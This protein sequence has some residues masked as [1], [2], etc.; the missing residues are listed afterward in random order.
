MHDQAGREGEE[1]PF[2]LR[3]REHVRGVDTDGLADRRELVHERDIEIALRVFNHLGRLGHPN[4]RCLVDARFDDG[5]VDGR[6]HIERS[7]VLR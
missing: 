3:R 6:D 4:G 5:A 1:I 2:G 7:L